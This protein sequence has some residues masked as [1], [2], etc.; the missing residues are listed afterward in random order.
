[1]FNSEKLKVTIRPL[2][3]LNYLQNHLQEPSGAYSKTVNW[4]LSQPK[5]HMI[6]AKIAAHRKNKIYK[7]VST[8]ADN[9]RN[10]LVNIC[11]CSRFSSRIK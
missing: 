5:A 7:L 8:M 2:E 3:V 1:M 6:K 9:Y 4:R 10:L 11:E